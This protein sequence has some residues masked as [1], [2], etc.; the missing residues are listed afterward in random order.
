MVQ[1]EEP[2]MSRHLACRC[3]HVLGVSNG[4][5]RPAHLHAG[6]SVVFIDHGAGFVKVRCPNCGECVNVYGA[7]IALGG[8]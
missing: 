3:G 4:A 1:R 6:V 2:L 7:R 5:D 8:G